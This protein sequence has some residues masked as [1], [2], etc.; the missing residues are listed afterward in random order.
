MG[1]GNPFVKILAK[2]EKSCYKNADQIVSVL[3]DSYK[4]MLTHGLDSI[5]K[6]T[7][8]PNGIVC[9]DWEN[10]ES[11]PEEH[12]NLLNKLKEENKFI[13]C[14]LG[15]HAVS[16]YLDVLIDTAKLCKDKDIAFILVGKGVEKER[17]ENRVKEENASNVFFLPPVNKKAVPTMLKQADILYIGA[18]P[19]VLYE[20]GVSMN[21]L[22]DYLMAGRPVV[23]AVVASNNEVE[24][25]KSG[26]SVEPDSEKILEA[27]TKL[28]SLSKEELNV[29]GKN[30]Q[31][32]VKKNCSFDVLAKEFLSVMDK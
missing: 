3:P 12:Q 17:L 5:D 31:D 29:M 14:Y 26:I 9:E 23:N 11:L 20:F 22:Y 2:A 15:G 24:Q 13:V 8:I 28:K 10:P 19:C 30:G 25:S 21:K 4:H 16:N 6:F 18:K 7:H 1:E 27:I 32:W